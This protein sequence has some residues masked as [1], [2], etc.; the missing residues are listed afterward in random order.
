VG[1]TI[2]SASA[3]TAPRAANA[4][5]ACVYVYYV[6]V[7]AYIHENPSSNSVIRDSRGAFARL[8]GPCRG[9]SGGFFEVY[10][11][12]C[13]DGLGWVDRSKLYGPY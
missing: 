13:T 5:S 2:G 7:F 11:S 4:K 6:R 12:A 9:P 10:S 1:A 3:A 8:T